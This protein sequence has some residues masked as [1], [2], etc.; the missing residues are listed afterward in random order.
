MS[1]EWKLYDCRLRSGVPVEANLKQIGPGAPYAIHGTIS[2]YQRLGWKK[3]RGSRCRC[4]SSLRV[5]DITSG[6]RNAHLSL[7]GRAV[8]G[9][10]HI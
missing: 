2:S 6:K 7:L 5:K 3:I 1:P 9:H 10:Q 8:Q 4:P